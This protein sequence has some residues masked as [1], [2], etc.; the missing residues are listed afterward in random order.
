M[1]KQSQYIFIL[2]IEKEQAKFKMEV[3][4]FS[5][6]PTPSVSVQLL[7]TAL[8]STKN[9]SDIDLVINAFRSLVF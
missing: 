3:E 6:K 8:Y 5:N 2:K 7:N 4:E 1:S 9:D